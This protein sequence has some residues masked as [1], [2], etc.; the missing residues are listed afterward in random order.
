MRAE[1]KE[2]LTE[3]EALVAQT[4]AVAECADDDTA[5]DLR[6]WIATASSALKDGLAPDPGAEVYL[7]EYTSENIETCSC[8]GC[9]D[10]R[11]D[12]EDYRLSG[13]RDWESDSIYG[14]AN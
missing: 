2:L 4:R 6:T 11:S 7:C 14:D 13:G 8:E 1:L 5:D 12:A 3:L 9:K 10:N